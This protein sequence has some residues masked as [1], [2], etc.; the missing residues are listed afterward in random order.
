MKKLFYIHSKVIKILQVMKRRYCKLI[1][2][3]RNSRLCSVVPG[4]HTRATFVSL[5]KEIEAV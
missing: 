3:P 4:V 5:K 1:K 2:Y